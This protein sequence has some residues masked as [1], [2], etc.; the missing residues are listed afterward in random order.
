MLSTWVISY[1]VGTEGEEIKRDSYIEHYFSPVAQDEENDPIEMIQIGDE[2]SF[3]NPVFE[4]M[5]NN[6]FHLI[7]DTSGYS[8]EQKGTYSIQIGLKDD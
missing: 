1:K 6:S 8:F 2:D 3:L 5:D 4:I 7:L